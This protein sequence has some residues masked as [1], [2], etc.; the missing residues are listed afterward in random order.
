M[1]S[2]K[3]T[4]RYAKSLIELSIERDQLI[5]CYN[6]L[7]LVNKVCSE[8]ND[9]ILMLNSPIIGTDKKLAIIKTIF[10]NKLSK[11]TLLFIEIITKK[12]RESLLSSI[13][14]SFIELYKTHNKIISASVITS[15]PLDE[16]LREK[17]IL[18]V[19]KNT[20]F[21]VELEEK[22]N[23]EIIG[24]S[25]INIGDYQLDNSVKAQLKNLKNSYNKNLYIKDF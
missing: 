12:K 19:Q 4:K 20:N 13:A 5:E 3:I 22:I 6:D 10:T 25:I 15:V 11:L 21:E 14:K 1:I 2:S 24:G 16:S 23:K 8:N 18:F 7:V 9:F 17:I